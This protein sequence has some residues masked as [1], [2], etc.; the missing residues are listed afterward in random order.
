MIKP[1]PVDPNSSKVSKDSTG[2]QQ[3]AEYFNKV[4]RGE[5]SAVEAYE[6]ILSK[7][8]D[9]PLHGPL[10]KIRNHHSDTVVKLKKHVIKK[11]ELPDNDSGVWGAFVS[12]FVGTA[13]ALGDTATLK[14]L[15]EG[16]EHGLNQYKDMIKSSDLTAQDKDLIKSE[17]LPRQ[18]EHILNLKAMVRN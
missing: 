8:S 9:D 4:L 11:A 10:S 3:S 15:I 2:H 6:S 18:E 7:F 1:Q 12:S 5:I 14:A 16:E 13:K 17:F